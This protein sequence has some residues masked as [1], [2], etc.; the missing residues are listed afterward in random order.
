MINTDILCNIEELQQKYRL[1]TIN[2]RLTW[3]L[4]MLTGP[5][6]AFRLCSGQSNK[7]IDKT[8]LTCAT[9]GYF[10]SRIVKCRLIQTL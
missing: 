2:N 1:R 6:L 3:G 5:D 7:P 4:N 10:D 9:C 8:F